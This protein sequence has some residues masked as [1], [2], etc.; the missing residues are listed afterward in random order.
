MT[1]ITILKLK[2]SKK[3]HM[4][5]D[6]KLKLCFDMFLTQLFISFLAQACF[7]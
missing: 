7:L 1:R 4:S 6:L 3:K 5:T 2:M